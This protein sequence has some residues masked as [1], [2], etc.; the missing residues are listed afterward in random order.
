[1]LTDFPKIHCPFIRQTFKVDPEQWKTFGHA[2]QL[3][4]PEAYLVIDKV[5]P[6]YEW[7]FEDP[8]TFAVEKL[9][10]CLHPDIAI[11]TNKGKIKIGKIVNQKMKVKV[12]SYNL[13]TDR[14]EY[15]NITNYHKYLLKSK[16]FKITYPRLTGGHSSICCTEE[17]KFYVDGAWKAAMDLK[18]GDE[19][20]I[21]ERRDFLSFI[22]QQIV[23][24]TVL[25]DGY[26]YKSGIDNFK[27]SFQFFQSIKQ[28]AYFNFKMLALNGFV[29][30]VGSHRG[31]FAGS[32]EILRAN[33]IFH[34]KMDELIKSTFLASGE[35]KITK[36]VTSN[37]SL[38]AFAVWYMDDGSLCVG[39]NNQQPRAFFACHRYSEEEVVLLK[40]RLAELNIEANINYTFKGLTLGLTKDGSYNFFCLIAPYIVKSMQYKLPDK[41][42][43]SVFWDFYHFEKKDILKKIKISEI[44]ESGEYAGRES[45]YVYDLTVEDN[46]NYFA[47]E[48]LVHNSNVKL[49]T[50]KGRLVELQ[51]R[52]NVLDPLQ[53]CK[54]NTAIIEGIWNS[55]AKGYVKE[56]GEQAGELIGPKLQGNP[57]KLTNHEW[58]PFNKAMIDLSYKSFTEH[59]R[60]FENW[61]SWFKDFLF[62]RY[63]TKRASKLGLDDKVFA[64]G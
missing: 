48:I 21:I 47:H 20:N 16:M 12:E 33:V 42:K 49:K 44:E 55:I 24:G 50:E 5:N 57:Y 10:G 23:L 46:S 28:E 19:I 62:S 45:G 37:L 56:D 2:L 34:P 39:S 15:K 22:Q 51:N 35:K 58:Y 18:V 7:V 60:T 30:Q 25:G 3:R 6:E 29:K 9:N 52:K 41:F 53:I 43:G 8:E 27:Y 26:I 32:T 11:Q 38:I 13:K 59:E 61:S 63:Y 64:E 31:G 54:G 4:K 40:Q 36:E 14:I 1:M 17:H